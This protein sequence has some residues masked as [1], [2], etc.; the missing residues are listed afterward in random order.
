M[1]EVVSRELKP[2]SNQRY[3]EFN[4]YHQTWSLKRVHVLVNVII[5]RIMNVKHLF[6][7]VNRWYWLS[8]VVTNTA[9]VHLVLQRLLQPRP[10]NSYTISPTDFKNCYCQ[11]NIFFNSYSSRMFFSVEVRLGSNIFP[12]VESLYSIPTRVAD[13]YSVPRHILL[14]QD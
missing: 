2:I 4:G 3:L 9:I 8:D 12:D 1:F 14:Y 13:T 10:Q 6:T 5:C 7:P 11:I